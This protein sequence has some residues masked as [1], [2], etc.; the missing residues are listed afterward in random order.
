MPK[1]AQQPRLKMDIILYSRG[2]RCFLSVF[3]KLVDSR[4]DLLEIEVI[5]EKAASMPECKPCIQ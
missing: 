5:V 3:A 4:T 2:H 1:E